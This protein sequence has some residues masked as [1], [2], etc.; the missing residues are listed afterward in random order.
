MKYQIILKNKVI[1][2]GTSKAK[3]I[4]GIISEIKKTSIAFS[5]GESIR[6]EKKIW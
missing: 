3:T 5:H 2:E 4:K 1:G 6:I